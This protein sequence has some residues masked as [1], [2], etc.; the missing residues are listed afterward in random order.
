MRRLPLE[1]ALHTCRRDRVVAPLS[2]RRR[3]SLVRQRHGCSAVGVWRLHYVR[4]LNNS[5]SRRHAFEL[6]AILRGQRGRHQGGWH[7][8]LDDFI[9]LRLAQLWRSRRPGLELLQDV[10]VEAVNEVDN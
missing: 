8:G 10:A 7:T 4:P 1:R 5:A 9:Q 2:W 3:G 6:Y